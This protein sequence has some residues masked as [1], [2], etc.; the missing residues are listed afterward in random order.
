MREP[1]RL[2]QSK[3]DIHILHRL[4]RSALHQIVDH[5]EDDEHISA[6]RAMDRDA[7]GIGGPHRARIRFASARKH[8][9]KGL[10]AIAIF[11]ELLKPDVSSDAC[12][13]SCVYAPNHRRQVWHEREAHA[14]SCGCVQL[15]PNLWP[16]T[17]AGY[18]IGFEIIRSLREEKMFLGLLSGTAHPGLRVR[19]QVIEVD[20]PGF[21]KG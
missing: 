17:M 7:A 15:L 4:S 10:V 1:H 8:I 18:T 16:M 5:C 3:H 12:I 19:D 14:P 6:T 13:Q 21:R 11:V 2:L 20:G 9:D